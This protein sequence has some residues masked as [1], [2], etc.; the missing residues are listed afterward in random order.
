V[1]WSRAGSAWYSSVP[2]VFQA[3][4]SSLTGFTTLAG[5]PTAIIRSGTVVPSATK[6]SAPTIAPAPMVTSSMI[7]AF[8]PTRALAPIRA[9]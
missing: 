2:R 3:S 4:M 5:L 1:A 9:P 6:D 7:T 8:M